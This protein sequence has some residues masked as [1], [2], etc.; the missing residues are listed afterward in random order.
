MD[1]SIRLY[2][3]AYRQQRA[4]GNDEDAARAALLLAISCRLVGEMAQSDGWLGRCT[5]LLESMPEGAEHGYSLYLRI[6]AQLGS[7]DLEAAWE[8]ARRMEAL[9]PLYSDPTLAC[10]G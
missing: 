9:G 2:V 1:E 3:E 5:R 4:A 10:Y 7:G 6:A 8:S